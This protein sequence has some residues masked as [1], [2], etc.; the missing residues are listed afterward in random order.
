[1]AMAVYP[2]VQKKAQAEIDAVVGSNRLPDFYYR[3][4]LPYVNAVVKLE[5]SSSWKLVVPLGRP[6]FII[7]RQVAT[8]L[9]SSEAIFHMST[10]DNEYNLIQF[11]V[12]NFL[13]KSILH[14]R[15]TFNPQEFQPDQCLKDGKLNPD[16][17]DPECAT[18]CN[19]AKRHIFPFC[20]LN[21][22]V[23]TVIAINLNLLSVS[24]T[25]DL[26]SNSTIFVPQSPPVT[27][28]LSFSSVA[29]LVKISP[30][31]PC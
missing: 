5:Q 6:F 11:S 4:S 16:V 10:I 14:R 31:C 13:F 12:L 28:T 21:C 1:M 30:G 15:K 26:L 7:I 19:V 22:I 24:T 18:P 25:H 2:E 8:I 20:F 9:T 29:C 27:S 3:P 23:V 17:R